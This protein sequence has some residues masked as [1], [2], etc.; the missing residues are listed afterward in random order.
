MMQIFKLQQSGLQLLD[1]S[2]LDKIAQRPH[3]FLLMPKFMMILLQLFLSKQKI[4]KPRWQKD[5]K[6]QIHLCHQ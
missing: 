4:L 2:M 1:I 3:E 5:Q 6:I